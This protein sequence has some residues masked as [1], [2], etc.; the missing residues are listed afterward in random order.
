[1]G[2]RGE[3]DF[4]TDKNSF[5]PK[6]NGGAFKAMRRTLGAG[7][8]ATVV[9]SAALS[10]AFAVVLDGC[11]NNKGKK[12]EVSSSNTNSSGQAFPTPTPIG[13]VKPVKV[14]HKRKTIVHSATLSYIDSLSGVS[15]R[16]PR[17]YKLTTADN[18]K[19]D[20]GMTEH[21]AM[22]FALPGGSPVASIELPKGPA[23]SFFEVNVNKSITP[24]QCG[25]F[26]DPDLAESRS[27]VS[28]ED[29][30]IPVKVSLGGVE[31]TKVENGTQELDT[32]YYHRYDHGSCYEFV[33]GVSERPGNTIAVDHWELF[34]K[35]EQILP[36]V[37][38][39]SKV[40]TSVASLPV[41][42]N[43]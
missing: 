31:F 11:S 29:G 32:R 13:Y 27:P 23:T 7:V 21:A 24:D 18:S 15:F 26:A 40:P 35:M 4:M 14:T 34:D 36:T 38:I 33:M 12:T 42:P 5:H 3:T 22:N 19:P 43:K 10:V 25:E 16:Y 28:T 30:S 8:T 17:E 37:V 6:V 39:K 2:S 1:M 9:L 41:T 20:W